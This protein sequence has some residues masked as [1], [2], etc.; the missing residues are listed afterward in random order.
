MSRVN[1]TG[2]RLVRDA[3]A[4]PWFSVETAQAY[5]P[6]KSR[7]AVYEWYRRHRIIRRS[8]GSVAKRDLDLELRK[9]RTK[10]RMA[11]ASLSNLRKRAS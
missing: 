8:N 11:A 2:P 7:K 5:I 10:W 3:F 1:T 9:P 4:G 6:C